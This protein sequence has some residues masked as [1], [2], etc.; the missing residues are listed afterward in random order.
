MLAFGRSAFAARA[1][2]DFRCLVAGQDRVEACHQQ[3]IEDKSEQGA[4][5]M[6]ASR[7][8]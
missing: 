2:D 4:R 8:R 1:V 7:I 5:P 3:T 6:L